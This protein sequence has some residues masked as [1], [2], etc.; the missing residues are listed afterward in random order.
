MPE[1][2]PTVPA[3]IAVKWL[4]QIGLTP[5]GIV[6]VAGP[7]TALHDTCAILAGAIQSVIDADRVRNPKIETA[8]ANEILT[9]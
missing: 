5:E 1:P 8:K 9:P 4:Y 2:A 3:P 7:I 6:V